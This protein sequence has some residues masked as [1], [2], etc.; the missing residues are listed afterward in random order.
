MNLVRHNLLHLLRQPLLQRLRHLG[1]ARRVADF[2]R[3]RV[4]AGVVQGVGEV[5]FDGFGGL[6]RG[7]C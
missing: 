6:V 4:A 1:I 3:L 7:A 5:V 2:A